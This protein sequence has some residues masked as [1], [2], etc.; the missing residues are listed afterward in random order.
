MR[1]L[2]PDGT[3]SFSCLAYPDVKSMPSQPGQQHGHDVHTG[4]CSQWP[5][6]LFPR[7]YALE[8][9]L[10]APTACPPSSCPKCGRWHT[11]TSIRLL[12]T[13]HK[14][15]RRPPIVNGSSSATTQHPHSSPTVPT[16]ST[17]STVGAIIGQ[18]PEA[19]HWQ[20]KSNQAFTKRQQRQHTASFR[21][22]FRD[23]LPPDDMDQP[24]S[25][26]CLNRH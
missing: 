3:T 10:P 15:S 26:H 11:P 9:V 6:H 5:P 13:Q 24:G 1:R 22:P 7:P 4:K 20:P 16:Y 18:L 14:P 23:A 8:S 17:V 2:S 19:R 12:Q 21:T 25:T